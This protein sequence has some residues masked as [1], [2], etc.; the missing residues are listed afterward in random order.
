[1]CRN[2]YNLSDTNK[3]GKSK[4]ALEK[5][6]K[7]GDI[8]EI[9]SCLN[10]I[11]TD[12]A[13]LRTQHCRRGRVYKY[14]ENNARFLQNF[15]E[16]MDEYHK[17]V[18]RSLDRYKEICDCQIKASQ[19]FRLEAYVALIECG[20]HMEIMAHIAQ[21]EFSEAGEVA[22]IRRGR[23]TEIMQYLREHGELS[24]S[25]AV[26]IVERGNHT[27]IMLYLRLQMGRDFDIP[28]ESAQA[29][30]KRGNHEEIMYYLKNADGIYESVEKLLLERGDKKEIK[31][32]DS[33]H[34]FDSSDKTLSKD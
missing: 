7:Q 22:L 16:A 23:H 18:V 13:T 28:E 14:V 31:I 12:L 26:A 21:G 10:R 27:E 33:L 2:F 3:I 34:N 4:S 29:L 11:E 30:V 8:N 32:A 9:R 6:I 20:N 15:A 5:M 1:M 19:K 17:E 24:V 25:A